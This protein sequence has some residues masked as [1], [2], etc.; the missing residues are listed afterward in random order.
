MAH[1]TD[2]RSMDA[3][4]SAPKARYFLL[5]LVAVVARKDQLKM[6]VETINFAQCY[7][8]AKAVVDRWDSHQS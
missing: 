4:D 2:A 8:E 6:L 5:D 3:V 7:A 1:K